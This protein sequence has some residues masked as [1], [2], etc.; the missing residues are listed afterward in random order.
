MSNDDVWETVVHLWG[1]ST[2]NNLQ[3][4]YVKLC[5]SGT[6]KKA[7]ESHNFMSNNDVRETVVHLWH[8]STRNY[9]GTGYPKLFE[10]GTPV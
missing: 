1:I 2:R 9:Y 3:T 5:N 8:I 4:G 6:P 7:L 10:S